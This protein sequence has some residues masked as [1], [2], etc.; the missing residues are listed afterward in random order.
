MQPSQ[1][2][3]T[4]APMAPSAEGR[5][6]YLFSGDNRQ[7]LQGVRDSL[8]HLRQPQLQVQSQDKQATTRS[9]LRPDLSQSTPDL[10]GKVNG[11][12]TSMS[13]RPKPNTG[14][15]AG[16]FAYNKQ[17]MA[18]INQSLTGFENPDNRFSTVSNGYDLETVEPSEVIL[19][20]LV[21]RGWDEVSY[22]AEC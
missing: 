9:N 21:D 17:A 18:E 13:P 15:N 22:S 4:S 1:A 7:M 20:E 10:L 3:A 11:I 14:G 2:T 16:R 6:P 12:G 19:K 8:S 5:R